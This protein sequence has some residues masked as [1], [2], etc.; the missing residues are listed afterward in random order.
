MPHY[1]KKPV[2]IEA[3]QYV[4][5]GTIQA[6]NDWIVARGGQPCGSVSIT[7]DTGETRTSLS[8]ETLEGT[9]WAQPGDYIVR[10]IE[11]E[12]YPCKPQIFEAT[13]ETVQ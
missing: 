4:G 10:G 12:F 2:V 6:V 7:Y 5:D 9:M 1:R 11:G 8:I 13:Y 3:L